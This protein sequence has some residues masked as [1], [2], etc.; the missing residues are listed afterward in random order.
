MAEVQTTSAFVERRESEGIMKLPHSLALP[1][2]LTKSAADATAGVL[3]GVACVYAGHPFD[4]V[5]V[6]MQTSSHLYPKGAVDCF[7]QT[8]R[9]QGIRGIY[10]GATPSLVAN[11][12]ENGVL[13]LCYGRIQNILRTGLGLEQ[14]APLTPVQNACAGSMAAFA[15]SLVLT[16]AELV[17]C[18][19]QVANESAGSAPAQ[20]HARKTIGGILRT[21]VRENG[22]RG[23]FRGLEATLA[24]EV[25]GNFAMFFGYEFTRKMLTPPGSD[26]E[27]LS[28]WRVLLSGAMSGVAFW[29]SVYP[30]DL[31]K[32]RMQTSPTK[33]S[34]ANMFATIYKESGVRGLYAGVGPCLVRAFPANAALFATVEFCHKMLD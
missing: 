31:V 3:G 34:F 10:A 33:I 1:D 19:L 8:L 16:P 21:T 7:A 15:T 32:S 22:F 23:L 28:A 4:T 13:F 12:G 9:S 6:K 17:K 26:G 14:D 29:S 25:P 27:H 20:P 2:W 11:V 24:R 5:K 18:Q 30:V